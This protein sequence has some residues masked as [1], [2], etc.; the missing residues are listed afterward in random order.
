M[1]DY[2]M[3]FLKP[4][5][6]GRRSKKNKPNKNS[7]GCVGRIFYTLF[8]LFL[9]GLIAGLLLGVGGYFYL[10]SELSGAIER[11]STYR[12]AA[13]GTP[14]F[15]DR[16]GNLLLELQ[17]A[18]KRRALAY[19]E[20]PQTII[21]ATIAVED[22][23]FWENWGFDPAA[24]GAA[25]LY[26]VQQE[27]GRPVGA[28]TI[29]QQLVRHIVF[30]FEERAA[31]SYERK[32]REIFLAFILTQERSKE[33]IL[34]LYLNEIYYGNRAYGIEAAAQTYFGKS[35]TDLNLGEAA[36]LAGLPQ[37]PAVWDPYTNNAGAK[38]RQEFIIDLMVGDGTITPLDADVAKATPLYIQP[39][40]GDSA[41]GDGPLLAPHFVLYVQKELERRYGP[42]AIYRGGWQIT[43]SLDLGFQ[44]LAETA[45]RQR[46]AEW[47]PNHNVSNA[48][49]VVLKPGSNEVLAMVGSLDYFNEAIDGQVNMALAP[50]QPGSSF[51]PFTFLAAMER[52]WS[53]ADVIWDVPIELEVGYN[54]KMVPVNYDRRYHG[55]VLLRD[56]LANSYNIPP[57]Q[58]ARD[59]GLPHVINTARKMGV[60]SLVET[61][62][63]YG[64]SLT[65][66]SG[67]IP[68]LEM[69][70]AYA[71]LASGGGYNPLSPVI[72]I[73]DSRGNLVFDNTRNQLPPNKVI[74][75]GMA[76]IITDILDDDQARIPAMGVG[77]TLQLAFPA[78]VKTGTTNDF[79]DNLTIGYTP[80]VVVGVWLG[81]SDSTPMR[82]T[83]GLTGAAP[84]WARLMRGIY[85]NDDLQEALLVNGQ[86]PPEE[87][88]RPG[89]VIEQEVC[90]PR[91]TGGAS[92]S[93]TRTDLTVSNSPIHGIARLGYTPD[94]RTVP[95]AWQLTVLP[96]SAEAASQVNLPVLDNGARPPRPTH[97]V[98]NRP[99]QGSQTRLFL[100]PPPF[101]ADEVRARL[102]ANQ[103]GWGGRMA[104]PSNCSLTVT[105]NLNVASSGSAA[106]EGG[107]SSGGGQAP[108]S[109]QAYITSPGAGA[110]VSGVVS[111]IGSADTADMAYYKLEIGSGRSPGEWTTFGTTHR[112]RVVDGVLESLQAGALPAGEYTIRLVIVREDGN[113]GAVYAVPITIQ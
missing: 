4:E 52:G 112:S 58:L 62:G 91:G 45:A 102:W 8:N 18:E 1:A 86:P 60:T 29:T 49:V 101:Y 96:L 109:G 43:T 53:T 37:A 110:G 71:T 113:Y 42:D 47:G 7:R 55:P 54:D 11:V 105:R 10:R 32:F 63:H 56:A 100:P 19:T 31:T 28:S 41:A 6:S 88:P 66:G 92:C 70:H 50:R 93:A 13:G 89:N 87:F 69:T 3:E 82:N 111:I 68:L 84:L 78:A 65:L 46:I 81:N 33:E 36:Y 20:M 59:V 77:N 73:T 15:F 9:A 44:E 16:N 83:S 76:Y 27:G 5:P 22:D 104:P 40:L 25:V 106:A 99:Y 35:A 74:N 67:E 108:I 48:A 38:E 64:L 34:T 14:R 85:A 75:E 103:N 80:G 107:E 95:G 94:T 61:P 98:T 39:L 12:S 21:D 23:T 2:E 90:L 57:L 24:I 51:K 72:K 30:T 79:R 97:C 26:N 17:T